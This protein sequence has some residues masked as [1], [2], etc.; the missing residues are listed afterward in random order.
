MSTEIDTDLPPLR[1]ILHCPKCAMRHFDEGEWATRPHRRHQCAYCRFRWIVTPLC[2]GVHDDAP[3]TAHVVVGLADKLVGLLRCVN[4]R[5][6]R[7]QAMVSET[8]ERL[9]QA[10]LDHDRAELTRELRR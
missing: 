6:A 5:N 3:D 9:H 7:Q 4:P 8:T 2:T 10:L 1:A